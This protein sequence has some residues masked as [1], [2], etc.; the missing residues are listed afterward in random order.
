MIRILLPTDGDY[1][2]DVINFAYFAGNS[3][4]NSDPRILYRPLVYNG[5]KYLAKRQGT[6][7]LVF[8]IM[9]EHGFVTYPRTGAA[10]STPF[11][12]GPEPYPALRYG[13][14]H[15][16]WDSSKNFKDFPVKQYY[17]MSG[18][19]SGTTLYS[20]SDDGEVAGEFTE[21]EYGNLFWISSDKETIYSWRG[22]PTRHFRVPSDTNIPTLSSSDNTKTVMGEEVP[23]FTCFGSNLY[24]NGEVL[25]SLPKY[26][27]SGFNQGWILGAARNEWGT[28]VIAYENRKYAPLY[29]YTVVTSGSFVRYVYANNASDAQKQLKSCEN[30][31]KET[32]LYRGFPT[33][34]YKLGGS[35]D[36]WTRLFE[37]ATPRTGLPW[38]FN[39]AG[40][41]AVSSLGATISIIEDVV[42]YAD[43]PDNNGQRTHSFRYGGFNPPTVDS[44]FHWNYTGKI[45][46]ESLASAHVMLSSS[47]NTSSSR[48]TDV[49]T[50]EMNVKRVGFPYNHTLGITLNMFSYPPMISVYNAFYG[51]AQVMPLVCRWTWSTPLAVTAPFG[52]QD[53]PCNQ[54]AT[55]EFKNWTG[56]GEF[57]WTAIG[58]GGLVAKMEGSHY[59]FKTVTTYKARN[60]TDTG[61]C[62]CLSPLIFYSQRTP[63]GRQKYTVIIYTAPTD[64]ATVLFNW[65]RLTAYRATCNC[66][67][68]GS[69]ISEWGYTQNYNNTPAS[70]QHYELDGKFYTLSFVTNLG[71][72]GTQYRCQDGTI[73]KTHSPSA[74]PADT[75]TEIYVCEDG[76]SYSE[77]VS[78]S[79]F[80]PSRSD[81]KG[82]KLTKVSSCAYLGSLSAGVY[83]NDDGSEY[84]LPDLTANKKYMI[85]QMD[86]EECDV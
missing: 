7:V 82:V 32:L 76:P 26:P 71:L 45:Y 4:N 14:D 39:K 62:T 18:N 15:G 17:P 23:E 65:G 36:G 20:F 5:N 31:D 53:D 28:F 86:I 84:I 38:F 29:E 51:S 40:T 35:I 70:G 69:K 47:S 77:C 75:A 59:K 10:M 79:T 11:R 34:V 68:Q 33:V 60:A 78:D 30:L 49:T 8:V 61:D 85:C 37:Q 2:E 44:T 74:C 19:A 1:P 46:H 63:S 72:S 58:S 9:R 27:W 64:F 3:L 41:E 42:F 13:V 50:R 6:D 21:L 56:C 16:G 57:T 12:I 81:R 48:V 24:S 25:A 66:M 73:Y 54:N 55:I 52:D 83:Y 80:L 22:T 67:S 43:A